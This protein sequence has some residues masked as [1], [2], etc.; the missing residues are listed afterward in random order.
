M[1]D[2]ERE[3]NRLKEWVVNLQ[4]YCNTCCS[5]IDECDDCHRKMFQWQCDPDTLPKLEDDK[6]VIDGVEV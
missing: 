5:C 1:I 2:W 6:E 4:P 3:Y